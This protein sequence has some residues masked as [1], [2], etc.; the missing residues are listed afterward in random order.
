ME[1]KWVFTNIHEQR[2]YIITDKTL[3]GIK[4]YCE[5]KL[6]G[7]DI[8]END[9]RFKIRDDKYISLRIFRKDIKN[10]NIKINHQPHSKETPMSI[11]LYNNTYVSIESYTFKVTKVRAEKGV[12]DEFILKGLT[13]KSVQEYQAS[14]K[15]YKCERVIKKV[16]PNTPALTGKYVNGDMIIPTIDHIDLTE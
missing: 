13:K 2:S 16:K 4:E 8:N 12:P 1:C 10:I 7:T 3:V 6:W 5:I 11:R 9:L 14:K 15:K